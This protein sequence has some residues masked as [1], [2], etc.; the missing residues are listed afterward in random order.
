VEFNYKRSGLLVVILGGFAALLLCLSQGRC[1]LFNSAGSAAWDGSSHQ[2]LTEIHS[3]SIFPDTFG[4]TDA[5]FG[6]MP[7]LNFYPPA[8]VWLAALLQH[9]RL[10]SSGAAFK[11]AVLIPVLLLPLAVWI[12]ARKIAGRDALAASG[13]AVISLFLLADSRFYLR[14]NSGIDL[15][16]TFQL[17]LYAQSLGFVLLVIWLSI[18]LSNS[19]SRWRPGFSAITLALTILS[20][21]FAA[22]VAVVF[23][24]ATLLC[25]GWKCRRTF[26]S[27]DFRPTVKRLLGRLAVVLV[28]VLLALFWLAPMLSEYEYFV[29]R[30][31]PVD[32]NHFF[33]PVLWGY[34]V[35]ALIGAAIWRRN[36]SPGMWPYLGGC[37]LLAVALFLSS[38]VA[39][40]WF[41]FQAP[42]L[43]AILIF[44][45][46]VPA[47]HAL[48]AVFRELTSPPDEYP[49]SAPE[50]A[51][52]ILQQSRGESGGSAEKER[53]KRA[54]WQA[55]RDPSGSV[56]PLRWRKFAATGVV[57]VSLLVAGFTSPGTGIQYS[58]YSPE[59]FSEIARI[60][61]YAKGQRDG[62]YLV[63]VPPQP[64]T[65]A[66]FDGRA[67]N[68]YLAAQGNETLSVAY[69]EAS[70]N[71]LFFLPVVNTLSGASY[72][73]G[74]SSV[75]GDDLD[76]MAQPMSKRLERARMVGVRYLVIHT[77]QIKFDVA[78]EPAIGPRHDFGAWS[79]FEL[80]EG[81]PPRARVLPYRP[82]LVVSDFTVKERRRNESSF[83]RWAEEQF[84][85]GWFDVLLARAPEKKIDR[86]PGL[87][88]FGAL[89]LDTY[90]CGDCD[91]AFERL[92]EFAGKR[93][94]IAVASDA[95]LFQRINAARSEFMRLEVVERQKEAP[96][97]RVNSSF[98]TYH[99][100]PTQIR[101]KWFAIR[102]ALDQNKV[103]TFVAPDGS[104][105][106]LEA[107][108]VEVGKNSI[109]LNYAPV[110]DAVKA[111]EPAP[112]LVATTFHPKWRRADG[113]MLY[114]ATPF[115]ILTFADGPAALTFSRQW[116]DRAALW[117]SAIT[118]AGL[119]CFTA[120]SALRN[121]KEGGYE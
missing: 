85:D 70:V 59:E 13:A 100:N 5:A 68:A 44:L 32:L 112:I 65:R 54:F 117:V 30:P 102:R 15:F 48:A 87:D 27:G 41:P 28:G 33:S 116:Y 21:F 108:P 101:R 1:R 52:L 76:F 12:A 56:E 67:I 64:E 53:K 26:G 19:Q 60:L 57:L 17:G 29:T 118:F 24:A 109:K 8:Q 74:I 98:P 71:S 93:L 25:D 58:F 107:V 120:R 86:L 14:F 43:L 79:V 81:P 6:G 115:Y 106:K 37:G 49:G 103:P 51:T 89:V 88:G 82:A 99:Y 72:H 104:P 63:E 77:P 40:E 94:L 7:Y 80:K 73:F 113:E 62:R 92:R 39:P 10:F 78:Q 9:S 45:L 66:Q 105:M 111:V 11:L 55:P 75:L 121:K 84:A 34:C 110:N 114:A 97:E 91:R 46:T 20:N 35:V 23:V 31:D 90:D 61:D 3:A 69:H 96:G 36:S 16:S 50:N 83:I 38:T 4:W 22:V 119:A 18:Y 2:A 47:G 42:R 95:P